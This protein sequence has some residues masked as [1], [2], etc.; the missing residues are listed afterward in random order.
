M[1]SLAAILILVLLT[2]PCT[3]QTK[4][5]VAAGRD[6]SLVDSVKVFGKGKSTISAPITITDTNP[7]QAGNWEHGW[8]NPSSV[9]SGV[10][11]LSR[12]VTILDFTSA[13]AAVESA[14]YCITS[15]NFSGGGIYTAVV[16][17]LTVLGPHDLGESPQTQPVD[18]DPNLGTAVRLD[19][20]H[21]IVDDVEILNFQGDGVYVSSSDGFLARRITNS[22]IRGVQRGIVTV[23][24]GQYRGNVVVGV[25]DWCIYSTAGN[26]QSSD[27]HFFAAQK[28]ILVA[29][30]AFHST[31]DV[32]ADAEYGVHITSG[33]GTFDHLFTQHHTTRNIDIEGG[34]SR[35]SNCTTLV[36]KSY[37]GNDGIT[38]VE[39]GSRQNEYTGSIS[40]SAYNFEWA[41][42]ETVN[43]GSVGIRFSKPGAQSPNSNYARVKMT[44][45]TQSG[46][47]GFDEVYD[48]AVVFDAAGFGNTVIVDTGNY[49]DRDN[50]NSI[51]LEFG[52]GI[53]AGCGGNY[54]IFR[55][56]EL[57]NAVANPSGYVTG[58]TGLNNTNIVRIIDAGG[59]AVEWNGTA[60]V[61]YTAD[62]VAQQY[63]DLYYWCRFRY[64]DYPE[65]ADRL[66]CRRSGVTSDEVAML[67]KFERVERLRYPRQVISF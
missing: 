4:I 29:G 54:I 49:W 8:A 46:G 59:S 53:A 55:G 42:W 40:L 60:W 11:G 43:P 31:N 22:T 16:S 13:Q 44:S 41:S 28:A 20:L 9:M 3:A 47:T 62:D 25:R 34:N 18:A 56:V 36:A 63:E 37:D 30:G 57:E 2:A 5:L 58:I 65:H 6:L 64:V 32:A 19:A 38:G 51:L 1:K 61:A 7:A 23:G 39:F 50:T 10:V 33:G 45:I 14:G 12:A 35:F 52:S 27:N 15:D 66:L 17:D 26:A 67:G 24:D 21:A 48:K